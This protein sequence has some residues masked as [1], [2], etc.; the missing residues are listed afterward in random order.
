MDTQN[1]QY[2][3]ILK[4]LGQSENTTQNVLQS[5]QST[6]P[7]PTTSQG[8]S[9]EQKARNYKIFDEL[10]KQGVDLQSVINKSKNADNLEKQIETMKKG[11]VDA[12]L[13]SIM[14]SAVKGDDEVKK[15]RQRASEIKSRI[16]TELCIRDPTYAEA[17][18]EYRRAVNQAYI[19]LKESK[20]E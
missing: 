10:M 3:N 14:E 11:D 9:L 6:Q 8:L 15:A 16:I 2:S 12:E 5:N 4:A 13:F 1:Q 18:H 7:M 19:R 20:E 17:L